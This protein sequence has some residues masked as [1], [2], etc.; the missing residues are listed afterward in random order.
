[1]P[2]RKA[3]KKKSA[4]KRAGKKKKSGRMPEF[5]AR[6]FFFSP[7]ILIAWFT[8]NLP[9]WLR[10]PVRLG[11]SGAF[12]GVIFGLIGGVFYYILASTYDLDEVA[13]MPART[14]ILDRQG[15]TLKN[16]RGQEIGF[17][18]GKNRHLVRYD[19]VS[20]LFVNALIAR[21][22]GRFR[23][24]G[25]VD[26]RGVARSILRAVT[27]GKSEGASTIT[28]Q[29]SRNSFALKKKSEGKII[30]F[31]RKALEIAIAHRIESR[32]S[33]DEI[34]EHYMNR[35]FWGGSIM[36]VESA[37]RTYFGKSASEIDL[38]EAALLAG[39]IRAPNA[40]SPFRDLEAAQ[41]ER[42]TVLARMVYFKYLT[43]EEAEATK[44]K[45]L[46]IPSASERIISGSYALDA[47][48]RDLEEILQRENIRDGG[49]V[50]RTT[51]DPNLQEVA[52][53]ALETRLAAVEK[54]AGYK[55]QKRASWDKKGNPAYLQGAAVVLDNKTG[56]V[57]AIVGGRDA[58]E[59]QFNRA[60]Q[61]RR[62]IGS[63]FKPFVY[64]AAV[65][66]GF[67]LNEQVSDARIRPGEISG[68]PRDWS[69]TNSDGKYYG[70]IRASQALIGSRN[71]SSVRV[72][73]IAGID[74]V[75]EVARLAGFEEKRIDRYPSS[76]L[77]S[78]G[79]TVQDVASAYSIFPNGGRRFRPYYVQS[80]E[81]RDGNLLWK[82][83]PLYY[84]AAAS[85]PAWEVSDALEQ[86]NR[87]GT[88]RA[89]RS[90]FGFTKPSGGKTG[91]TNDYHDAWYAGYTSSLSCAVWVGLD[92]PD[93]IIRGGEGARL[94]LPIWVDIMQT[95]DRLPG[96]K[97]GSIT[98]ARARRV[99]PN[100]PRAV[101]VNPPRAIPVR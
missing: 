39:I 54:T 75:V 10:W 40:F 4:K 59:S 90:R 89:I 5:T 22:D 69:P 77:G 86:V 41:E 13:K 23:E 82:S 48:R 83:G 58:G 37:S 16:S 53:R 25:A 3:A 84:E 93:Q 7:F 26:L 1:M 78:W 33:K 12:L 49:L 68:A 79:A 73:T 24:H 100:A 35:I 67:S 98:P 47:I 101:P 66:N 81:D 51:L 96:Y 15:K 28:M 92:S 44:A 60:L 14:E 45:P 97:N 57:L 65:K 19:E 36:G 21:E 62:P 43:E 50:I 56:G 20:P 88:G 2:P 9:A 17:L 29:L 27:R 55:H 8:R 76:Y 91:T 18:H 64:L 42:D 32:Y 61:S 71:T 6:K 52:E 34:L 63:I 95:A 11:L 30:R 87:S 31:H 46:E 80:I 85:G 38:S 94:A 99:E 74:E 70:S 72:G